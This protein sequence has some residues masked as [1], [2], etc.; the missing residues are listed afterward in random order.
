[1]PILAVSG[2]LQPRSANTAVLR[3]AL[4]MA[5][6]GQAVSLYPTIGELPFFNPDLDGET[7]PAAVTAWREALKA[8]DAVVFGCPEYM[9]AMPGVLKNALEWVVGSGELVGKPAAVISA[10]TSNL[11]GVRAQ[12]GLVQVLGAMDVP[13]VEAM[14]IPMVRA[15]LGPDGELADAET[16]RRLGELMKALAR[17]AGKL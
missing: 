14:A 10:S 5:P 12:I 2:S 8:A 3:A 7:P 15:K 1:M 9:Y 13:V 16:L 4:R 6:E 17:A 11:G